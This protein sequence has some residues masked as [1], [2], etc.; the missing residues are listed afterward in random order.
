M[1]PIQKDQALA[2]AVVQ[3]NGT[4]VK[5]VA[6]VAIRGRSKEPASPWPVIVG[7]L[8]GLVLIGPNSPSGGEDDP[9]EEVLI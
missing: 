8:V 9:K 4:V 5:E 2:K 1:A 7:G 3:N 6:L